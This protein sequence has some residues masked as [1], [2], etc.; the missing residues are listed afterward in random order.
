MTCR[1]I[2]RRREQP[3]DNRH[4]VQEHRDARSQAW[5]CRGG[6]GRN[7][8]VD[9]LDHLRA[10]GLDGPPKS[11]TESGI[12]READAEERDGR[13]H[14]RR[15]LAAPHRPV[16]WHAEVRL[17]LL[18]ARR[19]ADVRGRAPS[20]APSV[21]RSTKNIDAGGARAARPCRAPAWREEVRRLGAQAR[22]AGFRLRGGLDVHA[23]KLGHPVRRRTGCM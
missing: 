17:F 6:P 18:S 16:G 8:I 14:P 4:A 23:R 10:A 15:H 21:R 5:G 22:R 20:P 9:N 2:W 19:R 7:G 12:R 11:Y 13:V 3:G 1:P